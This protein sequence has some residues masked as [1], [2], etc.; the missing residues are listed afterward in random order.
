MF[1]SI[2]VPVDGSDSA[3]HALSLSAGIAAAVGAKLSVIHV[4]ANHK[5]PPDMEHFVEIEHIAQERAPVRI[6]QRIVDAARDDALKLGVDD[7]QTLV[8]EGDPAEQ[9]VA[10]SRDADLIVMGSR[11]LGAAKGLLMGSVSNKVQQLAAC[12]CMTTK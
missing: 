12:P 10:A 8:V 11:G 3:A 6:G 4:L 7:V 2:L 9:I 1:Q 5:L